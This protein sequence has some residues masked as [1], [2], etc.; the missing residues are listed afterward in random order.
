[1]SEHE[2]PRPC[3]RDRDNGVRYVKQGHRHDCDDTT[4]RGCEP[5]PETRHCTA[6]RSCSWHIAHG[7]LTCGRCLNAARTDLRWLAPLTALMLPA[8]I[9]DGI[10]SQ[11][12]N[13]AGPAT[14]PEA[15]TWRK[16]AAKQGRS[17]HVSL[18]E[19][20]DEH[21]P[22]RVAGTWARMV[23]EDY[24]HDMPAAASLAWC[25]GYLDRQLHRIAHDEEQDFPLLAREIRKCRQHLEAVLHNDDRPEMGAP[26]RSCPSP[27]PRLRLEHGHWC[28]DDD[29]R[30]IHRDD[31]SED[32]WVCPR[33]RDHWWSQDDYRRWVYADAREQSA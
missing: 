9:S 28:D 21:H 5:C 16:V 29:C 33:D 22:L 23:S 7:E 15:W 13:L 3:Y 12:A 26:C 25:V 27:A 6:K 1:M 17:W 8:A 31:D 32:R 14:D 30:K 24:G 2:K 4:C 19:E 11:A 18:I 20:D 10:D